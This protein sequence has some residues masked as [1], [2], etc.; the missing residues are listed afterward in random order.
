MADVFLKFQRDNQGSVI[1][2]FY[3][4]SM[5]RYRLFLKFFCW[6][7]PWLGYFIGYSFRI[8]R[9]HQPF[10][11]AQPTN[12]INQLW[13]LPTKKLEKS[14]MFTICGNETATSYDR[15]NNIRKMDVPH[16]GS[17]CVWLA[18]SHRCNIFPHKKALSGYRVYGCFIST[19]Q[20]KIQPFYPVFPLVESTAKAF[21]WLSLWNFKEKR[22][23][24]FY[25]TA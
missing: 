12:R 25:D 1:Y 13:N 7:T 19:V 22:I 8:S 3:L 4:Y 23:S 2:L 18:A 17:V 16:G 20:W 21:C 24:H 14:H 5:V 10:P 6:W 9:K 11:M 15:A